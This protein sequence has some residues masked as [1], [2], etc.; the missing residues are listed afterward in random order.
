[1]APETLWRGLATSP[2][3]WTKVSNPQIVS[4]IFVRTS[5]G[6]KVSSVSR[7]SGVSTMV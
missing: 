6:P 3:R 5:V 4:M 7:A 1:M 2:L